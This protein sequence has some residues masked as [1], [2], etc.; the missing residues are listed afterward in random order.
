MHRV[1]GVDC[2]TRSHSMKGAGNP[3]FL[4]CSEART[5]VCM[6][7]PFGHVL[8][9]FYGEGHSGRACCRPG[10]LDGASAIWLSWSVASSLHL[11][12]LSWSELNKAGYWSPKQLSQTAFLERSPRLTSSSLEGRED[13]FLFHPSRYY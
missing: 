1:V 10:F 13:I 8:V 9:L 11:F 12:R 5:Y 3:P 4:H 2:L 6:E 7:C